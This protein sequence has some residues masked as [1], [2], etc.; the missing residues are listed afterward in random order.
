MFQDLPQLPCLLTPAFPVL[1][2]FLLL[3]VPIHP[4]LLLFP[5]DPSLEL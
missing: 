3:T 5:R 1:P 2:I 4:H